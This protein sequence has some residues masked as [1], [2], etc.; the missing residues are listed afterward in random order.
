[1]YRQKKCN[2][3]VNNGHLFFI[4][5]KLPETLKKLKEYLKENKIHTNTH[6][7]PLHS[8][9][10]GKLYGEFIGDDYYT[11]KGSKTLLRLPLHNYLEINDVNRII[12]TIQKFFKERCNE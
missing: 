1:L 5:L 3:N 11:T 2:K 7:V 6:Y 4:K 8:S 9:K 10:A 12:N